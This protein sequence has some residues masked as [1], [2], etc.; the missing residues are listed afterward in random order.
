[1]TQL[2]EELQR[3]EAEL[4]HPGVPC[5][6]ERLE[7]LLH[8]DFHEVGRSGRPYTRAT[9]ISWLA[10][11]QTSPPVEATQHAAT[12]LS[13]N[14]ALLTYRSAHRHPDGGLDRH[15]FRSSVWLQSAAGW[16]LYYH[17]GTPADTTDAP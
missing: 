10:S 5:T 12:L 7:Q 8:P 9:V 16:R 13:A 15:T 3:L 6:R 1:M 2:T 14:C 4:H 17:Q 11:Q